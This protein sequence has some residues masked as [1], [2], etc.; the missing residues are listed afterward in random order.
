MSE[1]ERLINGRSRPMKVGPMATRVMLGVSVII[2]AGLAVALLVTLLDSPPVG[3]DVCSSSRVSGETSLS[4][5]QECLRLTYDYTTEP[6]ADIRN[7]EDE[8]RIAINPTNP[9][10]LMATSHQGTFESWNSNIVWYSMNGGTNWTASRLPQSRCMC[11]VSGGCPGSTEDDYLTASDP[12]VIFAIDGTAYALS[13]SFNF[14]TDI[15][16]NYNEGVVA[17]KSTDGGV[18]WSPPISI[19]RD[20][21]DFNFIDREILYADPYDANKVFVTWADYPSLSF[22]GDIDDNSV[23]IRRSFDG[24]TTFAD[25]LLGKIIYY[26]RD[27]PGYILGSGEIHWG[28]HLHRHPHSRNLIHICAQQQDYFNFPTSVFI[29]FVV[30]ISTDDGDTWG[31]PFVPLLDIPQ[32]AAVLPSTSYRNANANQRTDP[33]IQSTISHQ[34]GYLYATVAQPESATGNS[35][36]D[37][38]ITMSKDGGV[39]WTPYKS[40]NPELSHTVSMNPFPAVSQDGSIVA[41]QYYNDRHNV[42]ANGSTYD[43]DVYVTF[44]DANLNRVGEHRVTP[45]SFDQL[46]SNGP[47]G[48]AAAFLGDYHH[49]I[50]RGNEFHGVYVATEA[51]YRAVPPLPQNGTYFIDRDDRQ[52]LYYYKTSVSCMSRGLPEVPYPPTRR[53]S[54]SDHKRG[55]G[56]VKKTSPTKEQL[57]EFAM[58]EWEE[59][60]GKTACKNAAPR[61]AAKF[62][63]TYNP[64]TRRRK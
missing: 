31:A 1:R 46:A 51:S 57:F 2:I 50:A 3:I 43:L 25:P 63:V 42:Y 12:D 4:E 32:E 23:K 18:T 10:N 38:Y 20:N 22:L 48:D 6:F 47:S 7:T 58:E 55:H 62:N 33:S 54:V 45:T 36:S 35:G 44:F 49:L 30:A 60:R 17:W 9:L 39:T 64:E 24:M 59:S 26:N 37:V 14:G 41:V 11:A 15:D 40:I 61:L 8:A 19:T 16:E 27:V 21:G 28:C 34:T 52:N 13:V 29:R 5:R 53:R 56:P